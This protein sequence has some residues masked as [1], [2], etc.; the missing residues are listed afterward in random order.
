MILCNSDLS[1]TG[2]DTDCLTLSSGKAV[3]YMK[4]KEYTVLLTLCACTA[5]SWH[6]AKESL[7]ILNSVNSH[8]IQLIS[9]KH[10]HHPV[11]EVH[12]HQ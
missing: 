5:V 3:G 4:E 2:V 1:F 10:Q 7:K 9:L 6:R 8:L 11:A 12:P